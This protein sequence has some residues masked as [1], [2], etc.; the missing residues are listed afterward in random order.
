MSDRTSID[1][2]IAIS[3]QSN[4]LNILVSAVLWDH[5][6][7]SLDVFKIIVDNVP[8][9]GHP[10]IGNGHGYRYIA[11][12]MC[13]KDCNFTITKNHRT[14]GV[15]LSIEPANW[16]AMRQGIKIPSPKLLTLINNINTNDP[17]WIHGR[18]IMSRLVP[19]LTGTA[20][21]ESVRHDFTPDLALPWVALYGFEALKKTLESVGITKHEQLPINE[22]C[23]PLS[24]YY[25]NFNHCV[26]RG[27]EDLLTAILE[28]GVAAR[29]ESFRGT[30]LVWR[31]VEQGR[32]LYEV[33]IKCWVE[34][35][36]A[37]MSD[38]E[39]EVMLCA[40][41]CTRYIRMHGKY[42]QE[43]S[44]YKYDLLRDHGVEIVRYNFR[45]Y[46]FSKYR[47]KYKKDIYRKRS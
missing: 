45:M 35:H 36:E 9:L 16:N 10:R 43:M 38:A 31:A 42:Q 25:S 27:R 18:R 39:M 24:T 8:D 28:R 15:H 34:N 23:C 11:H 40:D 33:A 3:L 37:A 14:E 30:S 29:L 21:S 6:V 4:Y 5:L 2:K 1:R 20:M 47:R 12:S 13:G 32:T 17:A 19:W 41:P 46:E 7:P 26:C 44:K 22:D